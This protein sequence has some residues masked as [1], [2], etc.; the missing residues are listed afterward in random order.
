[1]SAFK[2]IVYQ[3]TNGHARLTINRP[4]VRNALNRETRIELRTALEDARE[5][6]SVRVIVVTGAGDKAFSAG[7]DIKEIQNLTPLEMRE[8]VK[9]SR[10]VTNMIE[11]MDK[12]VIAAVNGYA[13]GGGF[14]LAMACDIIVASDNARFGLPEIL[15]GIFPGGGGT[16]RLPK[17]IG[18]KKAKEMIFTGDMITAADAERMGLVNKVVP[19]AKLNETVE[20]LAKKIQGR[21]SIILK[22]AK[23]AL[24]QS[25]E[26]GQSAGLSYELEAFALCFSTEDQKEGMRAFIEKRQPIY[27]GR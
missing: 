14:E 10:N 23:S 4:E 8:Y 12:P 25:M 26:V 20:D 11:R 16:Q 2:N 24:N 13:L 27:K 6:D 17:L 5:D 9:L 15:I 3:K 18:T 21:S 7:A 22:L 19:A 1:M